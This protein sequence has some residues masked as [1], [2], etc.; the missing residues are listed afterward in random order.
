[1]YL[2]A[3]LPDEVFV[4]PGTDLVTELRVGVGKGELRDPVQQVDHACIVQSVNDIN[5]GTEGNPDPERAGSTMKTMKEHGWTIC[6][7]RSATVSEP[8]G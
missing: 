7:G 5:R 2:I 1:V 6:N 8:F 4:E 3:E